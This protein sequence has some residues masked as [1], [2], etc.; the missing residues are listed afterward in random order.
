MGILN[1]SVGSDQE[2]FDISAGKGVHFNLNTMGNLKSSTMSTVVDR[3]RESNPCESVFSFMRHISTKVIGQGGVRDLILSN[4]FSDF[5]SVAHRRCFNIG[6][7][8]RDFVSL[9]SHCTKG[10]RTSGGTTRGALFNKV[11]VIRVTAPRVPR[12]RQ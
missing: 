9:L 8:S 10:C 7:G 11:R 5:R 4:T 1:P 2:G 3:H 12:T 6:S